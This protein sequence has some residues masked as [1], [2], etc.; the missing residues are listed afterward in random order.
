MGALFGIFENL[1]KGYA[2][3]CLWELICFQFGGLKNL[4]N[5]EGTG[6]LQNGE[7]SNIWAQVPCCCVWFPCYFGGCMTAHKVTGWE[8]RNMYYLML[9]Y[10]GVG[11]LTSAILVAAASEMV[12]S[13]KIATVTT[14]FT[15]IQIV[16]LMT[17]IYATKV[18]IAI[19]EHCESIAQQVKQ[20]GAA[21]EKH[22]TLKGDAAVDESYFETNITPKNT[23]ITTVT[24]LPAL[25]QIAAGIIITEDKTM[26]NG[27]ILLKV[28]Y[29][30]NPCLVSPIETRL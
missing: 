30:S 10:I 15:V 23:W 9:Q 16:S 25:L 12:A 4:A 27:D 18:I 7:D 8:L 29:L 28:G 13:D 21:L 26:G 6:T 19:A 14:I 5:E 22:E 1:Y 20:H 24:A 2:Y 17:V 3:Y 11:A